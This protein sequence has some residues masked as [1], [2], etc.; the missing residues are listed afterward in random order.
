MELNREAD[1]E[2]KPYLPSIALDHSEH[3]VIV[4][5]NNSDS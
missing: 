5:G 2:R 4:K 1:D 3:L